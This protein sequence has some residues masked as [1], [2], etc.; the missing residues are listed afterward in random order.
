MNA[1]I[2]SA[3]IIDPRSKHHNKS[4]DILIEGGTISK[5]KK[6]IPA[7]KSVK[8]IN[9][10]NCHISPGWFDMYA[11]IGDPGY[12]HKEDLISG[13]KAAAVGGFTGILITPETQP[14]LH[15]KSEIEYVIN[16][17]KN[18]I[19]DVFPS[20]AITK[21]LEGKEIAE[22]MDMHQQGAVAF[23]EGDT[24]IKDAGIMLN[25]LQYVKAF[26]G[27]VMSH[28]EDS[29]VS[30]N[31]VMNE[32]K[33]STRLGLKGNPELAE[34]LIVM[35]DIRLAEYSD[36]S[37]H[38]SHI[39]TEKALN[40]IRKAR[41]EGSKITASVSAHHLFLDESYLEGYDTNYK[42]SP[43]L[44]TKDDIKAL[45]K[46][47]KDGA[48]D[49]ICSNHKPQNEELK[50]V[51]FPYAAAGIIGFETA[52]AVLNSALNKTLSIEEIIEK[53]AINPRKILKLKEVS[54]IEGQTANLTLFDPSLSWTFSEKDISSKSK[55]TPFIGTKFI[56]KALGII[57]NNKISIY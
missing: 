16:H 27:L 5:I 40:L 20:G 8:T 12:E 25:A 21:N 1:L 9:L 31:G 37:V 22:M 10:K 47:L 36:T 41:K 30:R 4:V 50:K 52:F 32:G 29:F 34:E 54:I 7:K 6:D 46:G 28:S 17:S 26:D 3:K 53:I 35:R 13:L 42:I 33:V 19:V 43:P 57:N 23:S 24:A 44:R 11:N 55:N 18:N 39:S 56:G 14:P 38:F 2:K 45:K 48:I 49:V 15:S 51:E